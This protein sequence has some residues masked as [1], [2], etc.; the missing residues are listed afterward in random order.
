MGGRIGYGAGPVNVAIAYG[1]TD[2]ADAQRGDLTAMNI[3]G[4]WNAG[5]LTVMGQYNKYEQDSTATIAKA[6][7]DN[8]S[9]GVA[10]PLG[11]GTIK[12]SYGETKLDNG[13]TSPKSTQ[14]GVGYVYDL[15]KRTAVYVHAAQIDNE[16]GLGYVA[17][18]GAPSSGTG[19]KSTGYEFGVRHSF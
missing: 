11:A 17:G 16:S 3:G 18:T 15:S 6:T 12:A 13:T 9:L 8:W 7:L 2:Q 4:S 5:F 14:V 1:V 19:F 10:V